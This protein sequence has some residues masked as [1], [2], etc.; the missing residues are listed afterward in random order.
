MC[1]RR[2]ALGGAGKLSRTIDKGGAFC[3]L[4][5]RE[6]PAR[7]S[8]WHPTF[9][10]SCERRAGCSATAVRTT[11]SLRKTVRRRPPRVSV[12]GGGEGSVQEHGKVARLLRTWS[13]FGRAAL[14][15]LRPLTHV[16]VN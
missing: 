1:C 15:D 4:L 13:N 2:C 11:R 7:R 3:S 10:P 6:D 14:A 12:S 5:R 8:P 16:L 9:V